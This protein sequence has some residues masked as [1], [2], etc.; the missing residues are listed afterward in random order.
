MDFWLEEMHHLLFKI[1]IYHKINLWRATF[2][3]IDST[4]SWT[5]QYLDHK[6]DM[7]VNSCFYNTLKFIC[8]KHYGPHRRGLKFVI[9]HIITDFNKLSYK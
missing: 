1:Y 3:L 2:I 9:N 6:N 7:I 5:Q 4:I 8:S